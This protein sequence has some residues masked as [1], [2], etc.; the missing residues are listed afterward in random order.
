M[1]FPSTENSGFFQ[2]LDFSEPHGCMVT[3][4]RFLWWLENQIDAT[5]C[6]ALFWACSSLPGII[7]K[8]RQESDLLKFKLGI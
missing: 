3:A 2:I 4:S 8:L 6:P 7:W 5:H 1:E